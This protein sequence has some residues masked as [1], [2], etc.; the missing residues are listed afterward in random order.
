MTHHQHVNGDTDF[1]ALDL[2]DFL[3][4][5]AERRGV[6]PPTLAKRADTLLSAVRPEK[7]DELKLTQ[8]MATD[9]SPSPRL[10]NFRLITI[11]RKLLI[12]AC[13]V[14]LIAVT[15]NYLAHLWPHN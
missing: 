14:G 10:L 5:D 8:V 9:H 15:Y 7:F 12:G 6:K 13:V 3:R 11:V 2:P 1:S 4:R